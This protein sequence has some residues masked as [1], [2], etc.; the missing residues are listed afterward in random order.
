ML[1]P[2]GLWSQKQGF[3]KKKNANACVFPLSEHSNGNTELI[4]WK[5]F[6]HYKVIHSV[7]AVHY[8]SLSFKWEEVD[9]GLD[10]SKCFC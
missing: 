2:G 3:F 6:I 9:Y 1:V 8:V 5:L 4:L 7:L 10:P